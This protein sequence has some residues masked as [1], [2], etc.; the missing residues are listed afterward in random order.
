[1]L[2]NDYEKLIHH[3]EGMMNDGVQLVHR[4][5]LLNWMDT[6]IPDLIQKIKKGQ[7]MSVEQVF[8]T[9]D[10]L[11]NKIT[12]YKLAVL[13]DEG[14]FVHLIDKDGVPIYPKEELL[15]FYKRTKSSPTD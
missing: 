3:L 5:H 10:L 13:R 15:V 2:S 9:G 14:K 6:Q 1:M 11:E 7:D 12:G 4:G 8:D